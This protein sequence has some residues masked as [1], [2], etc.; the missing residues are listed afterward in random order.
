M[1]EAVH[2]KMPGLFLVLT[3]VVNR[4]LWHGCQL[5]DSMEAHVN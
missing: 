4:H 1:M 2:S 5:N 3:C